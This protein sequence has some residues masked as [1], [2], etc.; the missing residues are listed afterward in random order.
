M[1]KRI[2]IGLLAVLVGMSFLTSLHVADINEASMMREAADELGR[3]ITIPVQPLLDDPDIVYP[4]LLVS[5]ERNHVNIFRTSAGYDADDI[6]QT[7]HYILL[8]SEQTQFFNS[9]RLR[10]GRVLFPAETRD[11]AW[12]ISTNRTGSSFQIGVIEDIGRNDSVAIRSLLSAYN[13]LPVA[14][15]YTIESMAHENT[16]AFIDD[17]V[18]ELAA[19]GVSI[20]RDNLILGNNISVWRVSDNSHR[21]D[22]VSI[23]VAIIAVVILAAYRQLYE[24]KRAAVLVLHGNS[25]IQA[26]YEI[27]GRIIIHTMVVCTIISSAFSLLIPGTTLLFIV[28]NALQGVGVTLIT[29][30]ASLITLP[31]I[32]GIE[33][34]EALKNRK[35]TTA[36]TIFNYIFKSILSLVLVFIGVLSIGLLREIRVETNKLDSWQSTAKYGIFFPRS[37]G[38]DSEEVS[39]GQIASTSTEVYGLYPALNERGA[40]FVYAEMYS[41]LSLTQGLPKG[42]FRSIQVNPNYLSEYPVLCADGSPVTVSEDETDW[43][44]LVPEFYRTNESEILTYYS[45]MRFGNDE[46]ESL[47]EFERRVFGREVSEDVR[48]Q[49]IKIIWTANGQRIFTFNPEIAPENGNCVVDPIIEVMTVNNSTAFDRIN[50]ITGGIGTGIKV[51]LIEGDT[52]LTMDSLEE[53]LVE[54]HLDDNLLHLIT[55]N[56][57][58][59]AE[60][61]SLHRALR[62][63]AIT[64]LILF[65]VLI[66]L[67]I[68]S[69]TLL[70]EKSAKRVAV[71]KLLGYS[72]FARHR[73]SLFV[74][75]ATWISLVLALLVLSSVP[76]PRINLPV[77]SFVDTLT[78]M[79]S[80]FIIEFVVSISALAIIEKR[81][82]SNIIKGEF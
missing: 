65:V 66:V 58:V 18:S 74:L 71:R 10:E 72:F 37:I 68:Q 75:V 63:Q 47:A 19:A 1:S 23:W 39:S 25:S 59:L 40:I 77:T 50:G 24:S 53:M 28:N 3:T 82:I 45:T 5:A 70:F 2:L 76:L 14:G 41:P 29:T 80:V 69:T 48:N 15:L 67:A 49:N 12:F 17:L 43:V 7:S 31:S 54:L 33:I 30:L 22:W 64:L 44:L 78:V 51:K 35:G 20:T 34:H 26:W 4:A 52:S 38:Y 60:L 46:M 56:D 57:Y 62:D 8:C 9:F 27:T 79:S 55:L 73:S 32:L 16:D 11:D 61:Q 42:V 21:F 13:S 6:P 81:R 36:I